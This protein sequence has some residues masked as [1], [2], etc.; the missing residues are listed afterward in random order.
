MGQDNVALHGFGKMFKKFWFNQLE[1][2]DKIRSYIL[3][4]GG[5]I[6]TPGYRVGLFFI[7]L[8]AKLTHSIRF[9][10]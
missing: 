6:Q 7:D 4:R 5:I 9:L 3:T 10:N 8:K 1:N 2:V